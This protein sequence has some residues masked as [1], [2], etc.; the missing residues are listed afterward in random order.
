MKKRAAGAGNFLPMP[1]L[2]VLA[3]RSAGAGFLIP[4]GR[5]TIGR[6]PGSAFCMA[7]EEMSRQHAEL[8]RDGGRVTLTDLGSTNGTFINE[9][10]L[11][12]SQELNSGDVIQIGRTEVVYDFQRPSAEIPRVPSSSS[13]G[14]AASGYRFGDVRGPVQAGDGIQYAAD[15][16]QYVA[17]GPQYLH[18][19]DYSVNVDNDYDPWDEVFQGRGPGRALMA[20]GGV[21]AMLGFGLWVYFILTSSSSAS[22][23]Q[24]PF[25]RELL[26]GVPM[27]LVGFGAFLLGGILAGIGGGM[28]KA[29]RKRAEQ[30][31][32]S[33]RPRYR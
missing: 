14:S 18:A 20:L 26:P 27:A 24:S 23:G 15:G 32:R 30:R 8:K 1:Q 31:R 11:R 9:R 17:H 13:T 7:D 6:G 19:N 28:S 12:G 10:P 4:D 3:G 16:N 22:V 29:A 25:A 5:S 2:W 33:S 21:I